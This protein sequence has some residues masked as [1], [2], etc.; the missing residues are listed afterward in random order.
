MKPEQILRKAKFRVPLPD[1]NTAEVSRTSAPFI[2]GSSNIAWLDRTQSDF[3]REYYPT[4]HAINSLKYYPNSIYRDMSEKKLRAKVHTRVA[5]AYQ[6]IITTKRLEALLGNEVGMKPVSS[7]P[8]Q[9]GVDALARFR[10]GWEEFDMELAVHEGIQSDYTTADAAVYIW[11]DG[12]KVGWRL[13]SFNKGDT[14]YPHFDPMTGEIALLGRRYTEEDEKGNVWEYLDVIDNT[15]YAIY[16]LDFIDARKGTKGWIMEMEPRPHGFPECPVA[17]HRSDFGPVWSASQSLID[18]FEMEMSQF[19]E[20]NLAYGVGILYTFGAEFSIDTDNDGTPLHLDSPNADAKAGFLNP[21]Q[22]SDGSSFAKNIDLLDKSIMRC[23]FVQHAPEIKSGTDL[24]GIAAKVM[25]SDPYYKAMEDSQT[26]QRFVGRIVRLFKYA[27]G[28]AADLE[29][30]FRDLRIK[31][32][33]DPFYFLSETEIVNALVQLTSIGALSRK[34]ATEIAYNSGYG[35][36][37]EWARVQ[38][39]EHDD[40]VAESMAAQSTTQQRV[41]PVAES[42]NE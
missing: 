2:S 42:R 22:D 26:Y 23:S 21:G 36:A 31:A 24:S 35:V 17:Y 11:R 25:N 32:Y 20:Y 19:C 7:S 41:N 12:E 40:L 15:H 13:F 16:K 8:R 39:Q 18:P 29:S 34:S 10:E 33:L 6:Q 27:Y 3:M 5:A 30:V 37:D 28:Q 38:Q 14:L 1:I 4:S 9:A